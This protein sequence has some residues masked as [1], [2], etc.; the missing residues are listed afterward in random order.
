MKGNGEH[1]QGLVEYGVIAV[2]LLVVI[3]LVLMPFLAALGPAVED[4]VGSVQDLGN[5]VE[6]LAVQA[7]GSIKPIPQGA[8]TVNPENSH[9][10]KHEFED[11]KSQSISIQEM[12]DCMDNGNVVET[13]VND[14][15]KHWVDVC[16]F[17]DDTWG[18]R[19]VDN[20]NNEITGWIA[21]GS[22]QQEVEEY[23]IRQ[24]YRSFP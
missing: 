21:K 10:E 15:N 12:R 19:V 14:K 17:D 16:K 1:G 24:G 9:A 3:Y 6:D 18:L 2:V 11:G 7:N 4:V 22:Y 5:R 13:W 8:P 23:L 20:G